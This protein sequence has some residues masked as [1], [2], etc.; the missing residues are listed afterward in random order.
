MDFIASYA[1]N[2]HLNLRLQM[3]DLLNSTIRFKQ[4]LPATGQKVE[5]ESFR[6]GTNA[7]IGVSYRF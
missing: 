4:E 6:P 1:I 7:E 2:K 5:V 3:K